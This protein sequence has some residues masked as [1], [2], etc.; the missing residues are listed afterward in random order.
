[1]LFR[2]TMCRSLAFLL[3]IHCAAAGALYSACPNEAFIYPCKCAYTAIGF[4]VIC[5]GVSSSAALRTPFLYL[6][7]YKLH[8]LALKNANLT[9]C[10]DFF[11]GLDVG[12]IKLEDS[13][14]RV[15]TGT[16]VGRKLLSFGRSTFESLEDK[17]EV[18][19]VR[20][21]Q[22]DLGNTN[23]GPMKRLVNFSIN[24]SRIRVL[25]KTWFDGLS[26]LRSFAMDSSEVESVED[27][28][29]SGLANVNMLV[30]KTSG[31]T[32][33]RRNYFPPIA[34]ELTYLDLS[35]NKLSSLPDD[36]FTSMP[37]L[38][39]VLLSR[40]AFHVLLRQPWVP[41]LQ[42]IKSVH[43][44]GNPLVCNTTCQWLV[45]DLA[46]KVSGTCA[47]PPAL[48]GRAINSI[49]SMQ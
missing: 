7:S 28:A 26:Q 33:L 2:W 44:D 10:A 27:E 8:T 18:L 40:N 47:A 42:H 45:E 14:F 48:A 24:R 39:T 29:L 25:R 22:L 31:L 41:V 30:W 21:S 5:A 35:D 37:V 43:L 9:V 4:R 46:D 49:H 13:D 36:I 19:Y 1:M 16:G 34:Y 38:E 6:A 20:R 17:L 23:L 3:V 12:S 15:T 11:A 32:H